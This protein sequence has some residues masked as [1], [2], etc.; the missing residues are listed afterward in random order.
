MKTIAYCGGTFDLPHSGHIALFHWVKKNFDKLIIGLNTDDFVKKY[1]GEYPILSYRERKT[2][3][4]EFRSVDMVVENLGSENSL[5]SIL[6]SGATHIV[7]GIDWQPREKYLKQL[8]LT[9]EDLKRYNL[10]IVFFPYSLPIRTTEIKKRIF[11]SKV[12]A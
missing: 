10:D 9:E 6:A 1:K 8:G 4:E 3:L 2:I 12:P 5:P 11:L 7:A